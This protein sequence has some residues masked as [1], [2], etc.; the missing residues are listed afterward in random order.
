MPGTP[1]YYTL[2]LDQNQCFQSCPKGWERFE[3]RCYLWSDNKKN[4]A[5]AEKF[6][7]EEGAHLAS[8]TNQNIHDYIWD[9]TQRT[10]APVWLG[11]TDLEQEGLWKWNDGSAW[12][13]TS[14]ATHRSQQPDNYKGW[15][16][17][18]PD[19]QDCLMIY[20]GFGK[21]GWNDVWC[22]R[23]EPFICSKQICANH[24]DK[25]NTDNI[26]DSF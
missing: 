17:K 4:Q 18:F 8:V 26:K 10:G 25:T 24:E 12:N 3:E 11:R 6:C 14:W 16:D 21:N 7:K 9:K 5:E 13:F 2:L 15:Q 19:G 20:D 23:S 22:L 1:I